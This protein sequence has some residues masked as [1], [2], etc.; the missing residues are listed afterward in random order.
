[1]RRVASEKDSGL[2]KAERS[3]SSVQGRRWARPWPMEGKLPLESQD[4][5]PSSSPSANS[6]LSA[7]PTQPSLLASGFG[8]HGS[9]RWGKNVREREREVEF[10]SLIFRVENERGDG[11]DVEERERINFVNKTKCVGK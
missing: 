1:M 8:G 6:A 2:E 7:G 11:R 10:W 3:A 9:L 5:D 4:A